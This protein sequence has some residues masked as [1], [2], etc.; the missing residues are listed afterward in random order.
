M[1]MNTLSSPQTEPTEPPKIP[2]VPI[3]KA[4]HRW[5][6]GCPSP[7]PLG[8]NARKSN[9]GWQDPKTRIEF[10]T[11]RYTVEEIAFMLKHKKTWRKLVHRDGVFVRMMHDALGEGN[12]EAVKTY[13]GYLMGK[14]PT[15]VYHG[16]APN[17][18]PIA[19]AAVPVTPEQSM[20]FYQAMLER[21]KETPA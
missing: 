20:K 6:P 17:A 1:M 12:V 15:T 7:N 18:P 11:E 14:P 16:G 10:F 9:E 4:G 3:K 2:A 5:K 13:L 21:A 8:R 19:I